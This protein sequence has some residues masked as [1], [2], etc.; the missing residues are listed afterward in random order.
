MGTLFGFGSGFDLFDSFLE[1]VLK[2][3]LEK[4]SSFVEEEGFHAVEGLR[5]TRNEIALIEQ[6]IEFGVQEF[7][8]GRLGAGRLH[9][10]RPCK[11][12]L[13][14]QYNKFQ[15][16]FYAPGAEL[17]PHWFPYQLRHSA[18]TA[19]ELAH[20]DED[21]QALL[22]HR[23]VN[24]TKRYTKT[25]KKRREKLAKMRVNPF[26]DLTEGTCQK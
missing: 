4:L 7:A 21:A 17:L 26:D 24:M 18:S 11:K 1:F 14:K 10:L 9:K 22:G 6:G 3:F 2:G 16:N 8:A 15:L 13:S 20:S 5:V 12:W 25:Q 23:T 19:T